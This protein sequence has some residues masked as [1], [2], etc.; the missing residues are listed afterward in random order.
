MQTPPLLIL[1]ECS[2]WT[3]LYPSISS[4]PSGI[5]ESKYVSDKNM[6]SCLYIE[7][8]AFSYVSFENLWADKL[9]RFQRQTERRWFFRPGFS[10]L[11]PWHSKRTK[12]YRKVI[13]VICTLQ[14]ND[15]IE[16]NF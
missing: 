8:Y 7:I 11:S 6:K 13:I 5:E 14:N 15:R 16:A 4:R 2:A 12:I 9:F 3:K 10:S 1:L